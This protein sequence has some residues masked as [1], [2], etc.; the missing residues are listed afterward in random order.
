MAEDII[1][2]LATV[3]V[4][5]SNLR[6]HG[7]QRLTWTEGAFEITVRNRHQI[8]FLARHMGDV[9]SVAIMLMSSRERYETVAGQI[10][11][12]T[13][14]SLLYQSDPDYLR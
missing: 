5:L 11:D 8:H 6:S 13:I 14:D 4:Q 9:P 1:D 2:S 10:G 7:S 12:T 3:K